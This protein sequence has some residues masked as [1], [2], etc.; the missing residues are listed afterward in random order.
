MSPRR[1]IVSQIGARE[2]YAV[3]RALH[4]WNR[5]GQLYTDVWC[6]IG[7]ALLRK[8]P[9]PLP[10]LANRYHSA[11]PSGKVTAYPFWAVRQRLRWWGQGDMSGE[12]RFEHHR[13]VG[14]SFGKRVRRHLE[15]SA[16]APEDS[17]FFGYD[18]GSREVLEYLADTNALTLVDQIDPGPVHKEIVQAEMERWPGWAAEDVV[19]YAPYEDRRRAEWELASAVVVNSEWSKEALIDEGV[20]PE[21]IHVVPLAYEPSTELVTPD[22]VPSDRPLRVLWLGTVS[23]NKGIQYLIEAA[24]MLAGHPITVTVVGPIRIQ[25]EAVRSAPSSVEFKGRVPRDKTSEYYR[26]ADVFV[27]PT[28]SDGFALTQLEAMAHGLP[29]IATPNCGRVV[30]DGQDGFLVP[31]RDAEAL[32]DAIVTLSDNRDRIQSM[33]RRALS[34]AQ[35]YTIN[36]VADELIS[37]VEA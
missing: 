14:A 34:T 33:A 28:V 1:W 31:A 24:R 8:G 23:V 9:S 26:W 3:P 25:D 27:L 21:K 29:V 15:Q 4:R 20:S 11:L 35:E 5:L 16:L 17:V 18:T 32:A 30:H 13:R 12:A 19:R 36:R 22:P 2:H 37:I 10:S 7:Q 6:S